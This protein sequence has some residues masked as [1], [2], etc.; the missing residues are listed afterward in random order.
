[1][2]QVVPG[3]GCGTSANAAGGC[4]GESRVLEAKGL[5]RG[6]VHGTEA[7][8]GP[9]G[10]PEVPAMETSHLRGSVQGWRATEAWLTWRGLVEVQA[11]LLGCDS[12]ALAGG[13][14]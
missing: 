4:E 1:M 10:D 5:L 13:L 7:G 14:T 12:G 8:Q 9:R 11:E 3:T 2:E 6:W